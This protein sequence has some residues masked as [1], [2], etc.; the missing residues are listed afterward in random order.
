M[1]TTLISGGYTL[2]VSKMQLNNL[3]EKAM[4][5]YDSFKEYCEAV[6]CCNKNSW[7]SIDEG[8]KACEQRYLKT[9][10]QQK[11]LYYDKLIDPCICDLSHTGEYLCDVRVD[12]GTPQGIYCDKCIASEIY[13][14]SIRGIQTIASCCGNHFN[15]QD[16][17]YNY[18]VIAVG[19]RFIPQMLELGYEEV[20]PAEGMYFATTFKAKTKIVE[21]K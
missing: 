15:L 8:C 7:S 2:E 14:L 12:D 20:P 19:E 21:E 6:E 1:T 13:Q 4:F 5:V 10:Q 17:D 9:R 18:P 11:R 3:D 16:G